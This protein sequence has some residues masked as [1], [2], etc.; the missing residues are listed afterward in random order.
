VSA[1]AACAGTP[2]F[3][4]AL[5]RERDRMRDEN[6]APWFRGHRTDGH[7]I[8]RRFANPISHRTTRLFGEH[9]MATQIPGG[10]SNFDFT[11]SPEA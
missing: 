8:E 5:S 10:W 7:C 1:R 11:L 3:D 4:T 2:N 6:S 9:I